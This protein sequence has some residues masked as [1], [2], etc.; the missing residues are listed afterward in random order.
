MLAASVNLEFEKAGTPARSN[1]RTESR[2]RFGQDRA[3]A[4]SSELPGSQGE[5]RAATQGAGV[6]KR[7]LAVT[8]RLTKSR[9]IL[10]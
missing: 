9:R 7:S 4:A 6:G 5:E 10:R 2:H 1:R 3:E 8:R